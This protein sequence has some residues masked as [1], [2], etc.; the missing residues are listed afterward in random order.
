MA[1]TPETLQTLLTA[2]AADRLAILG[3]HEASARVVAHYD[4]NNTYQYVV[5][6]EETHVRW[7]VDALADAGVPMPAPGTSL[8]APVAPKG[9]NPAAFKDILA[10]DAKHLAE[11]VTR[12]TPRVAGMSHARHRRMLDVVLGESREHQRLFEQAA[13]GFEDVL[14]KRTAGSPRVGGVLPKRWQ[15]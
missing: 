14:G 15:A 6:R 11:F 10:E 7:L 9:T 3:R 13:T 4:F 1:A 8:G 5:N 12:W 2:V